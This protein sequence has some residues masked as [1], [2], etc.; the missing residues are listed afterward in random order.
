MNHRIVSAVGA[1]IFTFSLAAKDKEVWTATL[2]PPQE[3]FTNIGR[4]DFFILEP[5]YQLVLRGK[6]DGKPHDL[7]INV[8][9]ET[10]TI[11]GVETRVVEER[12]TS[13][14]KL[15]EVSR[16]YFAV[17]TESRHVYYFGEDVDMYRRGKITSHEGSWQAGV[18]GAKPG[19]IM[20]G[21]VRVGDKYYQEQA[22]KQARDR[23]ENVSTN[24][25]VKTPGGTFEHCLKVKETTPLESGT[26]YKF[27]APGIGL[28]Q[29]GDLKLASH[30]FLKD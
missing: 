8:L 2:A 28:V 6:E 3:T 18:K 26:E 30:G 11:D 21:N 9:K 16:N 14:G 10:K 20:P 13:D 17:G 23:A 25:T 19:I 22:P 5:G 29:E 4:N 12:E 24:E 1:L 27:H 15:I 7:V